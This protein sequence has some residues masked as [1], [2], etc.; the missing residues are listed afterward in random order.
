M[1]G[2]NHIKNLSSHLPLN[3][4]I[5]C[6]G[7]RV[8]KMTQSFNVFAL[9]IS[10]ELYLKIQS[11][12]HTKLKE[13]SLHRKNNLLNVVKRKGKKGAV[14]RDEQSKIYKHSICCVG[15]FRFL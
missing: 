13:V 3:S 11:A 1:H 2:Q 12:L 5:Q 7:L 8:I 14:C 9:Y 4:L 10:S 6:L 15:K